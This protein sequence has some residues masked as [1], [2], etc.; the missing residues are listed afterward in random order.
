M[1][2]RLSLDGPRTASL[3][4]ATF[5]V[6]FLVCIECTPMTICIAAICEKGTS[7]VLATDTMVTNPGIPIEFEHPSQKMAGLAENCI[8]MTAGD[9]LAH[10]ELFTK[11]RHHV[12]QFKQPPVEQIVDAIKRCYQE[13]RKQEVC[14]R[15]LVPRG[16]GDFPDF[17]E[18]QR[19]LLPEIAAAIQ[20]QIDEYDYGLAIIVGGT[21]GESGHIYG[22]MNP[23]T[24]QCYDAISFHAIG[25]GASHALNALIARGCS[26]RT[27]LFEALMI[28]LEAKITA[29]NAPGVGSTTD[30]AIMSPAGATVIPRRNIDRLRDVHK[31]WVRHEEGWV[32]DVDNILNGDTDGNN[33]ENADHD[34][35][36]ASG[37]SEK[38]ETQVS[39]PGGEVR[40]TDGRD[41]AEAAKS[42]GE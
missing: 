31:K 41:T 30:M 8:A 34:R 25:T 28:V 32:G 27:P 26:S 7:L 15:L 21:T 40:S 11:V 33:T 35:A 2:D 17:Y 9:A 29:E 36:G 13:V 42:V 24:S 3:R 1:A 18:H 23:G 12:G 37:G 5:V 22:V 10:S 39:D 4:A 38:G 6:G 14:E 20:T 16:F 19:I